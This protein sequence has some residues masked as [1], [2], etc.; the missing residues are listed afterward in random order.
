MILCAPIQ[1]VAHG[2]SLDKW[3]CGPCFASAADPQFVTESPVVAAWSYMVCIRDFIPTNTP[4]AG[5][6]GSSPSGSVKGAG[7]HPLSGIAHNDVTLIFFFFFEKIFFNYWDSLCPPD[8][9]LGL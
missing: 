4:A 7:P 2:F 3:P 9:W 5:G 6:N 8:Q 1:C